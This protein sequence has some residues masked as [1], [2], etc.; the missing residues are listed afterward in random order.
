MLGGIPGHSLSMKPCLVT[1]SHPYMYHSQV[2]YSNIW[3]QSQF[4]YQVEVH[5]HVVIWDKKCWVHLT[6]L[7]MRS[8]T[9]N[10][11]F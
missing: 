11:L 3:R 8:L 2:K 9:K 1:S 7:Y 6:V 10:S 5:V 4:F